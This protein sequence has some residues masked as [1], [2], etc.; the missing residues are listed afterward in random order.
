MDVQNLRPHAEYHV[1]ARAVPTNGLQGSWSRWSGTFSFFSPAG[2]NQT[3]RLRFTWLLLRR[4]E[5]MLNVS[6]N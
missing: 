5:H 2:E 6:Y 4:V 1:R 3:N